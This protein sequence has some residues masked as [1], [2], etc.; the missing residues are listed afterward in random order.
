MEEMGNLLGFYWLQ[1]P[2]KEL[3]L[4]Y[5]GLTGYCMEPFMNFLF[6]NG[7]K[8]NMPPIPEDRDLRQMD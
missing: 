2:N 6:P 7:I 4:Y 3:P 1:G 8:T 5:Y